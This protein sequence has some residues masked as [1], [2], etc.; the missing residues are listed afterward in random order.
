MELHAY[1]G[2]IQSF[3]KRYEG[4]VSSRRLERNQLCARQ[5]TLA[6][7]LE[8]GGHRSVIECSSSVMGAPG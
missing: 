5:D 6:W 7:N 3:D 8:G 2:G 4:A 1:Y